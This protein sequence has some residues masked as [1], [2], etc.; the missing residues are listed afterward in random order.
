MTF[1]LLVD[2]LSVQVHKFNAYV[3]ALVL[4]RK[5]ELVIRITKNLK[6]KNDSSSSIKH[7]PL[8]YDNCLFT[9]DSLFSFGWKWEKKKN[10]RYGMCI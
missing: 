9:R 6:R 7:S 1:V 5:G 2:G 8:A 4:K 3:A 10:G